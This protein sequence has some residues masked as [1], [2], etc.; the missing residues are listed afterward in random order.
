MILEH[1]FSIHDNEGQFTQRSSNF[2]DGHTFCNLNVVLQSYELLPCQE[3]LQVWGR[4]HK[5]I[6]GDSVI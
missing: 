6:T 1:S 5:F 4:F 3:K 2:H